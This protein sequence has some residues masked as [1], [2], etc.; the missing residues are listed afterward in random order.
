MAILRD[1]GLVTARKDGL[2][3][4]YALRREALSRAAE[5]LRLTRHAW[6]AGADAA[7]LVCPYYNRPTQEGLYQHYRKIA[8]EV[9]IPI[10]I[11]LALWR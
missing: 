10:I 8:E 2:W 5:A 6:E 3:V 1:A 4:H 11:L 7:L 9:P